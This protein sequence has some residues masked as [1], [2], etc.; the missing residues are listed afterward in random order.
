MRS[1]NVVK[2][3]MNMR[4]WS[5]AKLAEEAGFKGQTNVTGMINRSASMK[6]ENLVRLVE[7]MGFEVIVRDKMGSKKEWRVTDPE[8]K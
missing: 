6:V 8:D 5:Q 7:A 1:A 4:D 3:I 2:E